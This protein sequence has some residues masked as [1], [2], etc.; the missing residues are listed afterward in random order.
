MPEKTSRWKR[1]KKLTLRVMVV[2]GLP[3]AA[4]LAWVASGA[5]G[6]DGNADCIFVP[7][8]AIRP[9]RKPSDALRYRL[10]GALELYRE[11]RAPLIVVSGGGEGDFAEAEVM[12]EW[13]TQQGVPPQAIITETKSG[14]TRENARFSAP[15]MRA[16]KIRTALVSTQW[17]HARRASLCLQQEGI[18]A[19]PA[20]CGG[21]T[22]IR[23]PYFVAREMVALPLYALGLD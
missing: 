15:L 1:L 7:G 11:G 8:A 19:I 18:E 22:L 10:E 13:L 12:A 3:A 2:V 16:R 23:E 21:N 5:F 20:A 17:F 14:T 4:M 6:P 9:G